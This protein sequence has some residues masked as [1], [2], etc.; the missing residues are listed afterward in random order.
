[1]NV[2][3]YECVFIYVL[4]LCLESGDLK[5]GSE[6]KTEKC[7]RIRKKGRKKISLKMRMRASSSYSFFFL[8]S[9]ELENVR[10]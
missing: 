2:C 6:S 7:E 1:M 9:L 4:V 5:S 8:L 3:V 10:V